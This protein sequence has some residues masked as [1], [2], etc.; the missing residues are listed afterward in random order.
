MCFIT[1]LIEGLASTQEGG[2]P[3]I[4]NMINRRGEWKDLPL[5]TFDDDTNRKVDLHSKLAEK[6]EFRM[7]GFDPVSSVN[8]R[9]VR[10]IS[11]A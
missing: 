9:I 6:Q 7:F 1:L 3:L 11:R 4:E 10:W 5:S 2:V 8:R